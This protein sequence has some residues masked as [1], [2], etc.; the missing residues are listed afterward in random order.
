M[1]DNRPALYVY[2]Q[3]RGSTVL[4]QGLIGELRIPAG[5][6]ASLLRHEGVQAHVVRQRAAHMASLHAQLEPLL[7]TYRSA[8]SAGQVIAA[9]TARPP[10]PRRRL[11]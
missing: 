2:Q 5:D 11:R 9:T 1:R 3:Q 8:G 7:L 10:L 4:Q 6:S